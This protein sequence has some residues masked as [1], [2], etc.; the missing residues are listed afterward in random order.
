V[1]KVISESDIPL[2][3]KVIPVF[4]VITTAL[5]K[6][7]DNFDPSPVVRHAALH[8]MLILNKY[9][10]LTDNSMLLQMILC[11]YR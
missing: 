9:Y 10:A 2:I 4:D 3:H 1:M 8:G 11:S 7:I 6:F 5:D